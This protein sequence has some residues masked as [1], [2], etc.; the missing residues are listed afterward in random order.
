MNNLFH[1]GE[2]GTSEGP[3][4][5]LLSIGVR[6]EVPVTPRRG[7]T[8]ELE[9][10]SSCQTKSYARLALELGAPVGKKRGKQNS[11]WIFADQMSLGPKGVET[12]SPGGTKS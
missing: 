6:N 4:A 11:S 9:V 2:R 5:R 7:V 12:F 10:S 8:R 3:L 1:L